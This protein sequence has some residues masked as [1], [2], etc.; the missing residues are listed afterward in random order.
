MYLKGSKYSYNARRHRSSPLRVFILASLIIAGLF[1][2]TRVMPT[3]DTP[4][5]DTATPTTPP[6]SFIN[7]ADRLFDEGRLSRAI[8]LYEQAIDS[9]PKNISTYI[10]LARAQV[11]YGDYA[12]AQQNAEN[13]ILLNGNNAVAHALRGWA[14]GKLGNYLDAQTAF[15]RAREIDPNYALTYAYETEVL[16][17]QINAGEDR[18]DTLDQ[19]TEDS[20]TALSLGN[21][22]METHRARG[23]LLEIT[24][25]YE[26]AITEFQI[27][28]AISPNLADLYLS[29]GSVYRAAGGL[30]T[31]AI[32]AFERARSLDP[33]NALAPYYISRTYS[34][35][36]EYAKAIQQAQ[37]AI[38]LDP[39]NTTYYWNLGTQYYRNGAYGNAL[40]Y[41]ELAIQ[42]G[43][44]DDGTVIEGIPL[45]YANRVSELYYMYGLLLAR[46]GQ[47][48]EAT[49]I[50]RMLTQDVPDDATAVINAE[51]MTEICI[52]GDFDIVLTD[53]V[54]TASAE[55]YTG[56]EAAPAEGEIQTGDASEIIPDAADLAD[57]P[58]E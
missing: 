28:I 4:F 19:A 25:N 47:C 53:E 39:T 2:S 20:R 15:D 41:F 45:S 22:L 38:E 57:Q 56:E 14:I 32:T 31:E 40:R 3:M 50:V 48:Q 6:E 29:L 42:G 26:D 58:I 43:V 30:D 12:G 8:E 10:S 44:A 11:F 34:G 55:A 36:G 27:A 13:A 16:V 1:F 51:Y 33:Y 24:G 9:D 23:Q 54:D 37:D 5:I 21:N 17:D 49:E 46:S 18:L 35:N 7:E 52:N